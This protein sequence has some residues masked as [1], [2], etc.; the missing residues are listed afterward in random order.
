MSSAIPHRQWVRLNLGPP[1]LRHAP[2]LVCRA[3][4]GKEEGPAAS[5]ACSSRPPASPSWAANPAAALRPRPRSSG[6]TSSPSTS[7]SAASATTPPSAASSSSALPLPSS[8]A[9]RRCSMC[10]CSRTRWPGRPTPC[11]TTCPDR[12]RGGREDRAPPGVNLRTRC[13]STTAPSSLMTP[14]ACAPASRYQLAR[15]P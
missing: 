10:R 3:R 15:R 8:L 7:S 1:P 12:R 14:S 5:R 6:S 4:G 2:R 13:W 9:A 11:T